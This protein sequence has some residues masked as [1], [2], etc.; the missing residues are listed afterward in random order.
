VVCLETPTWFQ[1]VGQF[2]R[3]F[4]QVEDEEVMALLKDRP[5]SA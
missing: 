3:D 2:Y 1:A 5:G 4:P